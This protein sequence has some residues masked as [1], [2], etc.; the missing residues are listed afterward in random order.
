MLVLDSYTNSM[1]A[2]Y[3]R[4]ALS[5]NVSPFLGGA[6]APLILLTAIFVLQSQSPT[7]TPPMLGVL[8]LV[9]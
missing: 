6:K 1:G 2:P 7:G 8:S 4:P 3:T 5:S 9:L